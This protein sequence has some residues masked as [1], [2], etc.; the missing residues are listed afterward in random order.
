MFMYLRPK[1]LTELSER[2]R[3][4]PIPLKQKLFVIAT[5]HDKTRLPALYTYARPYRFQSLE[6]LVP[7][8]L[9]L[10]LWTVF[11]SNPNLEASKFHFQ[12]TYPTG[13]SSVSF[14]PQLYAHSESDSLEIK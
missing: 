3:P 9:I 4:L 10:V 11:H 2:E 12:Q 8:C 14:D 1:K 7:S 13:Y 5:C 6:D